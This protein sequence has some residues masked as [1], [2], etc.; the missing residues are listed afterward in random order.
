MNELLAMT[1]LA[2]I[3]S[4]SAQMLEQVRNSTLSPEQALGYTDK[5]DEAVRQLDDEVYAEIE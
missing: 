5:M 1:Y 3:N 4:L 2:E